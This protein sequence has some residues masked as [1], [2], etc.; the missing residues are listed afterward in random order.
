AIREQGDAGQP[1]VVAAPES[2]AA[3]AYLAAATRL[4]EEL[5][6]RPRASIPISASLL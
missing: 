4:A 5:G 3:K 6:K 2:V 1:V